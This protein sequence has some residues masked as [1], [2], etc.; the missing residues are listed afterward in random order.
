MKYHPCNK[1]T[2]C[3]CGGYIIYTNNARFSVSR[4]V[5]YHATVSRTT[6]IQPVCTSSGIVGYN[7]VAYNHRDTPIA[8]VQIQ[9]LRVRPG[10]ESSV[11]LLADRVGPVVRGLRSDL[12]TRGYHRCGREPSCSVKSTAVGTFKATTATE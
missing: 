8:C 12:S 5:V 3:H 1:H 4:T 2:G 7:C 10:T 11:L 6:H 9:L